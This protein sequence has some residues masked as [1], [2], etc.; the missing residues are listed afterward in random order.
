VG[1]FDACRHHRRPRG[2]PRA[3]ARAPSGCN[4]CDQVLRWC[5]KCV[6]AIAIG[7][8]LSVATVTLSAA[9]PSDFPVAKILSGREIQTL[10]LKDFIRFDPDYVAH[11]QRLGR[12]LDSLGW[13]LA[14]LQASGDHMECSN[15]IYL[16]A[17]WLHRYTGYW[18][19][20][21]KRLED[22]QKSLDQVNQDFAT[23]QSP[24]T[25]LW[26]ACYEQPFF[27]LEATFLALIQLQALGK[28]PRIPVHLPPPFNAWPTSWQHFYGLLISDIAHTGVDN[29]GEL[30]NIATIASLTYLKDYMQH[31]LNTEVMGLWN[32][33]EPGAKLQL[34]RQL[35]SDYV[36][37]WQDPTTG[38]WGPW[39]LS[40]GQLYD[41]T[42]LSFTFHII[43]YRHGK[44]N[45]WPEIIRTT[46]AIQ[47]EPYPFGFAG[48]F[49][50]HNDYDVAKILRYAWPRMS[51]EQQGK[52]AALINGMLQWTL[53]SSLQSD[54]SFKVVP[55]AFSSVD[56]DFYFG[57]AFLDIA[58]YWDPGKRFWTKQEFPDARSTCE[59]IKTKLKAL[60]PNSLESQSALATLE[61]AC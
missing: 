6:S 60:A 20:L 35:F 56:A 1:A 26:G 17:K 54:G 31:Y 21:K 47:D 52:A 50:N 51:V 23:Q 37:A 14:A 61:D 16:E 42:D 22:L 34:Y 4:R 30:G 13:R 18:D 7:L 55:Q 2:E 19:R 25:G 11:R 58:G 28:T 15:E 45:Y 49:T 36:D 29:R 46:L 48:G 9:E 39:Y 40:D 33:A 12:W 3:V 44:V 43:S 38:Y 27:K 53:T 10:I 24:E 5:V 8:C 59:R 41:A 32:E 57:V